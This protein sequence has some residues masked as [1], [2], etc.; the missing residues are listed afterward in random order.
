MKIQLLRNSP[1]NHIT[2]EIMSS[3]ELELDASELELMRELLGIARCKKVTVEGLER[4]ETIATTIL[5]SVV[6]SE[7][8]EIC[9]RETKLCVERMM[10][11]MEE[12]GLDAN[13]PLD[14]LTKIM[15]TALLDTPMEEWRPKL[16][17][18]DTVP[19]I[20]LGGCTYMECPRKLESWDH[21]R[22]CP[23]TQE[24]FCDICA[25]NGVD[26]LGDYGLDAREECASNF[27]VHNEH[28]VRRWL[29]AAARKKA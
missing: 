22:I 4:I 17:F 11:L 15:A 19:C 7:Y 28:K 18:G 29:R 23:V 27:L 8:E 6:D 10:K 5:K 26:V 25:A 13:M 12:K 21:S 24:Y 9:E 20:S 2:P 1:H 14:T 3:T 16:K